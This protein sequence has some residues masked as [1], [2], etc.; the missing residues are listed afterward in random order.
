MAPAIA[1]VNQRTRLGRSSIPV[2]PQ[3]ADRL[4]AGIEGKEFSSGQAL[5]TQPRQAICVQLWDQFFPKS[6][7]CH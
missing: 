4:K 5:D 7:Q 1:E 6:A 2:P 3:K